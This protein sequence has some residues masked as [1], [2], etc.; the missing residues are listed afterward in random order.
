MKEGKPKVYVIAL[1]DG[2][3]FDSRLN[4]ISGYKGAS[5]TSKTI[6]TSISKD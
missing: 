2:Q 5:V 1:K 3:M 6:S 4:Q